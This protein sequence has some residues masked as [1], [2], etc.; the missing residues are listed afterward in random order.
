MYNIKSNITFF[1]KIHSVTSRKTDSL[2]HFSGEPRILDYN[3][4]YF[5]IILN[6]INNETNFTVKYKHCPCHVSAGEGGGA[7]V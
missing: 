5:L 1:I 3:S 6:Y 4:I 7:K 2:Q